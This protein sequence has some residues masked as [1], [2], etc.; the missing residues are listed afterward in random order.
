MLRQTL[1]WVNFLDPFRERVEDDLRI[2]DLYDRLLFVLVGEGCNI[3]LET[4]AAATNRYSYN[5]LAHIASRCLRPEVIKK[6]I[7]RVIDH[8]QKM[9]LTP[10]WGKGIWSSADGQ[11]FPVSHCSLRSRRHPKA[12]FAMRVVNLVTHVLDTLVS[13]SS[14][15]LQT[16][17]HENRYHLDGLLHHEADVHPRKHTSDTAGYTDVT[18][19]LTSMLRIFFAPRIRSPRETRLYFWDKH[20]V[21]LLPNVFSYLHEKVSLKQ[22]AISWD[23][24]VNL[25]AAA[26]CGITPPSRSMRKLEALGERSPL[27]RAI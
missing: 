11:L 14:V 25:V 3:G 12:P 2:D 23:A 1:R 10:L 7:A 16:T 21:E 13:Y 24:I 15:L 6:A 4:M 26:W 9:R 20:D 5:Q 22:V 17:S 18:F 27:Y 8:H 19:G